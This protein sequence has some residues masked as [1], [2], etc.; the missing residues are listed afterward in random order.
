MEKLSEE[1]RL[2]ELYCQYHFEKTCR[3]GKAGKVRERIVNVAAKVLN[4]DITRLMISQND[5]EELGEDLI[6][7]R[8]QFVHSEF[9]KISLLGPIG[10]EGLYSMGFLLDLDDITEV[11]LDVKNYRGCI[12]SKKCG[13]IAWQ[14]VKGDKSLIKK[15]STKYQY[16]ISRNNHKMESSLEHLRNK[17]IRFEKEKKLRHLKRFFIDNAFWYH[18]DL[19]DLWKELPHTNK[20]NDWEMRMALMYDCDASTILSI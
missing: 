19:G 17:L 16:L 18:K 4:K 7:Y 2:Y 8:N 20:R 15:L 5:I 6:K 14:L 3:E 9:G 1:W 11:Y 12:N 10:K 13:W